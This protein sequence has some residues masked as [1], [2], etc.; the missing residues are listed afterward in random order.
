[1]RV[2]AVQV[3]NGARER[4]G[5]CGGGTWRVYISDL[6]MVMLVVQ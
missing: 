1:M 5:L 4:G 3:G 6:R 2:G